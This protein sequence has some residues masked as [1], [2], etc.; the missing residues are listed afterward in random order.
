MA[1]HPTESQHFSNGSPKGP[2]SEQKRIAR[3]AGV[4][5][6]WT[7]LSRILGF[8]R[9]MVIA[10]FLGAGSGA[11]A[12][13][14]AFRIPNLL[15]RLFAEGALSAA[16]VPT[17]VETLQKNGLDDAAKLARV[18]F[19]LTA[20]VLAAITAAGILF[21]P[22]IV[23]LFAPGF[24]KDPELFSLTVDLNRLMFPYI[25]FVS[26]VALVSGVLNSMGYFAAPAAAPV[27]LNAC[28]IT[29]VA[30]L[31][32]F[33]N[34]PANYALAWGVIAAGFAQLLLQ[35]PF[36]TRAGIRLRADF[37]F[38][39]P[40]LKRIGKLFVPA[41]IS[42]A[43][44]QVNVLIGTI[45]ASLLQRGAVSW[46]YYADRLVE[47]PLGIF[48]IALGTAVLPSMSRLAGKGN[49]I[50]LRK[51][52]SYSLRLIAFF[53]IPASVG[54]IILPVPIIS[55]LFQRGLFSYEDT[56]ETAYALICYTVGLWA[57]S[58]LKIVLQAFFALK[59]TKTP[60]WV[61]LGAVFVNLC[62]G[63]ILMRYM[64]QGGLALATA[65]AASF[66]LSILFVILIRRLGGFPLKEFTVSLLKITVASLLMGIPLIYFRN[67][68]D[69][70]LGLTLSNLL[71]LGGCIS[72]GVAVFAV[73][74]CVLRC[75]ELKSL[76]GMIRG[77][78]QGR[79]GAK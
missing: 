76:L 21:S 53:T 35:L 33:F 19:T 54:L 6:F 77:M 61:S 62:L 37:E 7:V 79:S 26:L 14:V 16:F 25:F 4:V 64:A 22:S 24:V 65:L 5:G 52:V 30:V 29:S 8:V 3:A 56:L 73:F 75:P 11:D 10:L 13:F 63:V 2:P 51:S 70:E 28:M 15:R 20:I 58:G 46:L 27:V 55:I 1:S 59:D 32:S 9:D 39:S 68:G 71:I 40:A 69:W 57:F 78:G 41:A 43:V 31:C 66:N 72:G 12:F 34:M 48:A 60:L 45:L 50:G 23:H 42:G 38:R 74:A 17:Y 18:A 44:Y 47:L 36:L 49:M 67:L